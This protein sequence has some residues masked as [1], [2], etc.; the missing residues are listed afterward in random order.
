MSYDVSSKPDRNPP[1]TDIP[2][3]NNFQ[4][5]DPEPQPP[6]LGGW[7]S[8]LI[9]VGVGIVLATVGGQLL[10]GKSSDAPAEAQETEVAPTQTVT[11]APVTAESVARTRPATGTVQAYDLLPILPQITGLQIVDVRV[12][13][14]DRVAAGEVL[15]LLDDSVLQAQLTGALSQVD[16]ATS[17]V[18]RAVADITQAESTRRQAEAD[19]AQAK[20]GVLQAKSR[21]L[22]AEANR[23]RA[24][25]AIAQAEANL[26]QA[27]REVDRYNR[28]V[29]QGAISQQEAELRQTEVRTAREEYNKAIEDLQV[30]EADVQSAKADV[31][32]AEANVQSAQARLD[33]TIAG[34]DASQA[35]VGNAE[36]G[37]QNNRA[38]VQELQTRIAQT[39][40]LAPKGGI[41]AERSARVGDV[42]SPSG[43]LFTL[44]ADGQLELQLTVP[45]TQLPLVRPGSPVTITSDAD[46]RINLRGRVREILPTIDPQSREATVEI[47][48]PA[49][50][51]LRPGMFLQAEIT[52]NTVQGLT[53]PARAIVP[54]PD[55]SARVFRLNPDN[56]VTALT[57]EV[58]EVLGNSE[59]LTESR[60]EILGGLNAG[61]RIVVSGAGYLKDGDLVSV[62]D[63]EP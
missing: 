9:G 33:S 5:I 3:E 20:T 41:I 43:R 17:G 36:A 25:A 30:A 28:L 54:Q 45:E 46:S 63:S 59:N 24:K 6:R 19:L 29:A 58:G 7:R 12:D 34:I 16:S 60:I 2:P 27:Q 52:T 49:S 8:I 48:L 57:V 23:D 32:N 40:V 26:E 21:V 39:R 35:D 56:T 53:I 13:E 11:V 42:T 50:D 51:L 15:A 62:V 1:K 10:S 47:D 14:G 37:V 31:A 44:I 61:D 38:V 18:D 4:P 55:A 22:Q